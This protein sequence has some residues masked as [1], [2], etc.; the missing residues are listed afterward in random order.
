MSFAGHIYDMLRR[1]KENRELRQRLR[2]RASD[3]SDSSIGKYRQIHK[4]ISAEEI[5]HIRAESD[6]KSAKEARLVRIV[7]ALFFLSGVV[8]L[9][10]IAFFIR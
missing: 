8:I 6:R 3:R 5:D 9:F 4:H 2:N 1:D 7:M 10:C